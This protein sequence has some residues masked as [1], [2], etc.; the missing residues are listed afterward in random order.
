[1]TRQ[2]IANWS[3]SLRLPFRLAQAKSPQRVSATDPDGIVP[4]ADMYRCRMWQNYDIQFKILPD[5]HDSVYFD[6]GTVEMKPST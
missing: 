5:S 4:Y 3:L 2:L 1:M 6:Q